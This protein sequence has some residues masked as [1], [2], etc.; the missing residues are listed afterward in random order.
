M[1]ESHLRCC[2]NM[3]K[4]MTWCS[5]SY[6]LLLNHLIARGSFE[7][8]LT[9]ERLRPLL[10]FAAYIAITFYHYIPHGVDA[11]IA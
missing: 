1:A 9:P 10:S 5:T 2:G 4:S 3:N 6:G 8:T 7:A 11:D